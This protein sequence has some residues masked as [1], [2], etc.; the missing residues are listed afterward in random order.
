ME[1]LDWTYFYFISS[2]GRSKRELM[3]RDKQI[4]TVYN[5]KGKLQKSCVCSF[6]EMILE[7]IFVLQKWKS[8]G[9]T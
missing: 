7:A 8:C 9:E 1:H 6:M 5:K 3:S 2:H 4:K